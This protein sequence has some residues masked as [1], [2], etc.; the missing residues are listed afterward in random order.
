MTSVLILSDLPAVFD[1]ADPFLEIIS[2]LGSP[3]TS[4]THL[5]DLC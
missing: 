1:I 5:G 3:P 2:S 4:D